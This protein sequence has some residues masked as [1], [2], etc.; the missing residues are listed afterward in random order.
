MNATIARGLVL[1][2]LGKVLPR[3]YRRMIGYTRCALARGRSV[4]SHVVLVREKLVIDSVSDD[5]RVARH[6]VVIDGA[7]R[8]PCLR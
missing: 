3:Q 2:M 6:A 7:F 8:R 4:K 5:E 1:L